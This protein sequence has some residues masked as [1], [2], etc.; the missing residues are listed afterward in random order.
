MEIPPHVFNA[1]LMYKYKKI[2]ADVSYHFEAK[3]WADDEN[4]YYTP[5]F[6]SINLKLS[7]KPVK[8]LKTS[9]LIENVTNNEH[10]NNKGQLCLGRFILFEM[11][12]QFE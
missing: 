5:G 9:V 7:V 1:F 6:Y 11:K 4:T 10:L 12:Y 2:S 3:K 8:N